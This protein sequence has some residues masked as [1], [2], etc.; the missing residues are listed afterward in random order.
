M[1]AVVDFPFQIHEAKFYLYTAKKLQIEEAHIHFNHVSNYNNIPL[2]E[3]NDRHVWESTK[4][5]LHLKENASYTYSAKSQKDRFYRWSRPTHKTNQRFFRSQERGCYYDTLCDPV[6]QTQAEENEGKLFFLRERVKHED[7]IKEMLEFCDSIH[8]F[9]SVS[10]LTIKEVEQII[11]SLHTYSL[12][13]TKV[14]CL[15]TLVSKMVEKVKKDRKDYDYKTS[16]TTSFIQ[17]CVDRLKT[18][19]DAEHF[20]IKDIAKIASHLSIKLHGTTST[21]LI[22]IVD[23]FF[24]FIPHSLLKRFEGCSTE[25]KK[26]FRLTQLFKELDSSTHP[27]AILNG[28]M[29]IEKLR[30][31]GDIQYLRKHMGNSKFSCDVK[32]RLVQVLS[33]QIR[34]ENELKGIRSLLTSYGEHVVESTTLAELVRHKTYKTLKESKSIDRGDF[35]A[36]V[37]HPG[38]F[39]ANQIRVYVMLTILQRQEPSSCDIVRHLLINQQWINLP[40]NDMKKVCT[41]WLK[42]KTNVLKS[43]KLNDIECMYAALEDI[44]TTKC[45]T[46]KRGITEYLSSRVLEH[47]QT[48]S[49]ENLIEVLRNG[50]HLTETFFDHFRQILA[51][52]ISSTN[53]SVSLLKL[54]VD[55]PFKNER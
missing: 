1:Y 43:D 40:E 14:Q 55:K 15:L 2:K 8:L 24:P 50:D 54:I 20:I 17:C 34:S 39:H 45:L 10:S 49:T 48:H 3:T 37:K 33:E 52:R 44:L 41:D 21:N 36:V 12:T 28:K 29:I 32:E 11:N 53:D 25:V 6:S 5:T 26:L 16:L 7:H 35:L 19:G 31:V 18:Q 4:I 23:D 51:E 30:K 27:D 47:T 38:L 13:S 9:E 42:N 22:D 46:G